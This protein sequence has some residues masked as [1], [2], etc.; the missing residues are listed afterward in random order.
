[1]DRGDEKS[2]VAAK[3]TVVIKMVVT[4]KMRVEVAA[5]VA[6]EKAA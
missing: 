5:D 1:M 2:D 3:N 6:S 4:V